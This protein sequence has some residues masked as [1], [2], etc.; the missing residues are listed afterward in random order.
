[1]SLTVRNQISKTPKALPPKVRDFLNVREF[2]TAVYNYR[3]Q[4]APHFSYASWAAE[5]GFKSRSYLRLVIIGKRNFTESSLH[6]FIKGLKL[7]S[8][9]AHHFTNLVQFEQSSVSSQRKFNFE[10]VLKGFK[11]SSRQIQDYYSFFS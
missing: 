7:N 10:K 9:D 1:M 11:K 8:A 4:T 5:F 3:R 2:L 6:L